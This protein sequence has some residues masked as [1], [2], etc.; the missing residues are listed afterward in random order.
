MNF[1]RILNIN[2]KD[3]LAN[4]VKEAY[5]LSK[6]GA[7]IVYDY[8]ENLPEEYFEHLEFPVSR[9]WNRYFES[10]LDLIGFASKSNALDVCAGTGT[11]ILNVMSN[12]YFDSCKAIDI[13]SPAIHRLNQ[14]IKDLK[15]EGSCSAERQNIMETSF[16]DNQF[17]AIVGNSFLHHLPNN[18]EF[19]K[20]TNRILKKGGGICF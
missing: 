19:L 4:E 14:R 15:L 13:S 5:V 3:S 6:K 12:S 16:D 1:R 9:F 11:L 8:N 7:Q 10:K 20:E 17:D 2:V 18:V